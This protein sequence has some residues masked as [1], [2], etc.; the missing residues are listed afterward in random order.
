MK[1]LDTENQTI[2]TR[3]PMEA[4]YTLRRAHTIQSKK[5]YRRRTK[6]KELNK[7]IDK[8]E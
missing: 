3:L 1:T 8:G 6:K 4:V 5:R 7:F 2:I